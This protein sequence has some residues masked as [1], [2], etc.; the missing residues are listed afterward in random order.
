MSEK[1][2]ILQF[3]YPSHGILGLLH[4]PWDSLPFPL[5][6]GQGTLGCT[7]LVEILLN[8]L[9]VEDF[10]SGLIRIASS[11]SEPLPESE[12]LSSPLVMSNVGLGTEVAIGF[13]DSILHNIPCYMGPT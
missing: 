8:F 2:N 11:L 12:L 1:C 4:L 5:H 13:F 10:F 3:G 6:V 7:Q 9:S